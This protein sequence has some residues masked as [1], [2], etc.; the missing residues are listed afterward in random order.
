MTSNDYNL[1]QDFEKYETQMEFISLSRIYAVYIKT[2]FTQSN[3]VFHVQS[4]K[5]S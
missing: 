1:I 4:M 3:S 2:C 5:H